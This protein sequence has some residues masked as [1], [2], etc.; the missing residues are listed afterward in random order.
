MKAVTYWQIF[1]AIKL[2]KNTQHHMLVLKYQPSHKL[3]HKHA[4]KMHSL[5]IWFCAEDTDFEC[6]HHAQCSYELYIAMQGY[7]AIP[8]LRALHK[9]PNYR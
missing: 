4:F 9:K 6:Y 1:R 8:A 7:K 5:H 3:A 2:A